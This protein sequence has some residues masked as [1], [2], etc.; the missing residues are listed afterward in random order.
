MNLP[1]VLTQQG[2]GPNRCLIAQFQRGLIQNRSDEFIDHS[3]NGRRTTAALTI[4]YPPGYVLTTPVV[5]TFDP[6]VD[7][8]GSHKQVVGYRLNVFPLTQP[9][10][11]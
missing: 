2:S 9:K 5:K 6:P 3:R 10:Q 11:C 4:G 7:G 8:S 1:P